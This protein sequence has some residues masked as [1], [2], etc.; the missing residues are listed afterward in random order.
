MEYVGKFHSVQCNPIKVSRPLIALMWN[1][2]PLFQNSVPVQTQ[3]KCSSRKSATEVPGRFTGALC[4]ADRQTIQGAG[5][6][7]HS[8]LCHLSPE[9]HLDGQQFNLLLDN[10]VKQGVQAAP[11]PQYDCPQGVG[12][13]HQ[14]E[15][16]VTNYGIICS[17]NSICTKEK[18]DDNMSI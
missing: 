6:G 8:G 16:L 14:G 17:Q 2:D 10:V 5:R 12:A 11:A 1:V 13:H 9:F 7:R 18:D 3:N 4:R 15:L